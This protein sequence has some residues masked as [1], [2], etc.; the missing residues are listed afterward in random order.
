M[1]LNKRKSIL[2]DARLLTNNP[3]GIGRIIYE[4][5]NRLLKTENE[6]TIIQN[7]KTRIR[8]E[9]WEGRKPE[10]ILTN[11]SSFNPIH[12]FQLSLKFFLTKQ[13][14]DII[15][16]PTYSGL[17]FKKNS[18]KIIM[19]VN[20]LMFLSIPKFLSQNYFL[21][22]IK[23]T[24]LYFSIKKSLS[25][26]DSILAVSLHTK[27]EILKYF[28][29]ES[30]HTRLGFNLNGLDTS[31]LPTYKDYYLYVGNGRMHKNLDL[32]CQTFLSSKTSR[33]LIIIGTELTKINHP[34]IINFPLVSDEQLIGYYRKAFCFVFPSI[35]EGFGIPIIEAFHYCK[36]IISSS[37]GSLI[38][39]NELGINYFNPFEG[40]ELKEYFNNEEIIKEINSNLD[41][42]KIYNWDMYYSSFRK[43]CEIH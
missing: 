32:L 16:F 20:D 39:F 26:S 22:F 23:K 19:N 42:S 41:V 7:R 13:H 27:S 12:V 24:I 15:Y 38:E 34:K 9:V 8:E 4:L 43:Q 3:T 17:F 18:T 11:L 2:I 36:R 1:I 35:M 14:Y 6:V 5:T 28:G 21:N 10:I 31:W 30:T 37:G 25:Q 40:R 33:K 29:Q